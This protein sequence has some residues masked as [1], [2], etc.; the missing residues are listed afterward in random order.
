[1]LALGS[2][3]PDFSLRDVVSGTTVQRDL[4]LGTHGLLVMF[5]SRHCPYVQ[6]VQDELARIGRDY[7]KS[8]IGI[9]AIGA[10]DADAHPADAPD[11]LAEQAREA[12]FSF[13]YA[14]DETQD[15]ARAF[16]A[17]CTPDFFLYDR[18]L[19]L[20]YRGQLDGSR[21]GNAVPV[22]GGDLRAAL[23]ALEDDAPVATEQRPSMGC[24]IKWR[25]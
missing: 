18:T 14:Y 11:R 2:P 12:G 15:V 17:A 3:A 24:N 6:H 25:T 1:M 4:V 19:T 16:N 5:L 23:D 9:V 21:P 13:A 7:A 10:N 20:V 22:T 8:G